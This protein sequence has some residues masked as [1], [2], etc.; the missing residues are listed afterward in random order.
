MKA[1]LLWAIHDFPAYGHLSGCKTA[2]K[3]VC[4]VCS[5]GTNSLWLNNGNKF[6]YM[7]HRK[8]LQDMG[9]L[10]RIQKSQFDGIEEHEKNHKHMNGSELLRKM[11]TIHTKFGKEPGNKRNKKRPEVNENTPWSKRSI[12]FD[13]PYWKV[14]L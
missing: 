5:E 4:P 3:Y 11:E 14:L 10:F 8:W 9:H 13:L 7:G 6:C 2:G 12:L 1:T